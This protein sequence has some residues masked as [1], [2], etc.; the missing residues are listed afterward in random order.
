MFVQNKI[1]SLRE[2]KIFKSIPSVVSELS[3]E[4]LVGGPEVE[5]E[6]GDVG[7]LAADELGEVPVVVV[8]NGPDVKMK[9]QTR[10]DQLGGGCRIA[11]IGA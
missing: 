1:D 3:F 8:Q 9:G 11:S 2:L 4:E 6:D 5:E 7:Q 10:Q